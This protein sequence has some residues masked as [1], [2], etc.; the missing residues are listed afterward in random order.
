MTR[1][2]ELTAGVRELQEMC[3]VNELSAA[4]I[5]DTMDMLMIGVSQKVEACLKVHTM[6]LNEVSNIDTEIERLTALKVAPQNNAN[7]MLEYVKNNMLASNLD[8]LDAGLFRLTLRKP[9][10]R[11]GE[12]DESLIPAQYFIDVPATRKLDKRKLL[13]DAKLNNVSGANVI[14]SER[15]LTIK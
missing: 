10:Q 7:R 6:Q 13:S 15:S 11:L 5:A 12:L 1:L 14:D 2:F 4:D 9:T 3:D 8:K